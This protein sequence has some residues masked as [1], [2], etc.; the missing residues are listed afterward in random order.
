MTRFNFQNLPY[1]G[2]DTEQESDSALTIVHRRAMT[3]FES[4]TIAIYRPHETIGAGADSRAA[5]F[6]PTF[7]SERP[8]HK[9]HGPMTR[10]PLDIYTHLPQKRLAA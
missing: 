4:D 1:R 6:P 8:S 10:S 9:P 5:G 2:S 3:L 7:G